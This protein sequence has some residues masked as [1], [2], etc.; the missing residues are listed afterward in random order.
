[1]WGLLQSRLFSDSWELEDYKQDFRLTAS[2]GSL[3]GCH[4]KQL[5]TLGVNVFTSTSWAFP[6]AIDDLGAAR[7]QSLQRWRLKSLNKNKN[8][9]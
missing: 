8:K 3:V 1:V 2:R 7:R 6:V 5:R 9:K 4:Y